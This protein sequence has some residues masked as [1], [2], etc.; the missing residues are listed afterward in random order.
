MLTES[1]IFHMANSCVARGQNFQIP[2]DV[3][4]TG[5]ASR[6]T[7]SEKCFLNQILL[8]YGHLVR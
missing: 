7:G 5:Q 6:F 8:N 3:K 4:K 2:T 1:R